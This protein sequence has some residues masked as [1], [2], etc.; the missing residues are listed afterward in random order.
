M[1]AL[2]E[3]WYADPRVDAAFQY[4]VR[5]APQFPVGLIDPTLTRRY[6][7]YDLFRA[8]G[9]GRRPNAPPPRLP[10]RCR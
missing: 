3:R 8:W 7:A 10:A 4:T 6:P 2:L 1:Q 9:G 5:E